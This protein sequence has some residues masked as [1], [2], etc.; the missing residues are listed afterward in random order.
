MVAGPVPVL[1]T[2]T[3]CQSLLS[4]TVVPSKA[5]DAGFSVTGGGTAAGAYTSKLDTCPAGQPV[6][7]VIAAAAC[8]TR[9]P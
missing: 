9:R 5:R 4:L 2:V 6:L 7:A 1:V 8:R 3:V